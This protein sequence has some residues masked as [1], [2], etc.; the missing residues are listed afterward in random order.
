[1]ISAAYD[2]YWPCLAPQKCVEIP[3]YAPVPSAPPIYWSWSGPFAGQVFVW[4]LLDLCGFSQRQAHREL[5]S[6]SPA[7]NS[8]PLYCYLSHQMTRSAFSW[9]RGSAWSAVQHC[10]TTLD[11]P[12]SSMLPPF[13]SSRYHSSIAVRQAWFVTHLFVVG[14]W[15]AI[16]RMAFDSPFTCGSSPLSVSIPTRVILMLHQDPCSRFVFSNNF[17]R[18]WQMNASNLD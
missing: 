9:L 10:S 1:M 13:T 12:N 18:G 14:S 17:A 2:A 7:P 3:N 4:H 8:L 6:R 16:V 5:N 15:E 11:S